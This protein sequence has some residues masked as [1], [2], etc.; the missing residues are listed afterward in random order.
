MAQQVPSVTQ[1]TSGQRLLPR[2]SAHTPSA[3][4]DDPNWPYQLDV[5]SQHCTLPELNQFPDLVNRFPAMRGLLEWAYE[6][7]TLN[8]N[9]T[10][11]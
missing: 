3:S 11:S 8:W 9:K 10:W 4:A 6:M 2:P 1:A 7:K 5:V